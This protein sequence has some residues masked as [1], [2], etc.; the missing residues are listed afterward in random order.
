MTSHRRTLVGVILFS[1]LASGACGDSVPVAQF[2]PIPNLATSAQASP[3][4]SPSPSPKPS[5]VALAPPTS[6]PAPAPSCTALTLT[7]FDA[8]SDGPA[9]V[10][11]TWS[12]R[13]GCAPFRGEVGA[14]SY[15]AG[16]G[17]VRISSGSGSVHVLVSPCIPNTSAV[18]SVY[19]QLQD[20]GGHVI[21]PG[22]AVK[23][24]TVS[25]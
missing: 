18:F 3:S 10:L 15:T 11:A 9:Q 23:Q 1:L 13:G 21:T 25:C 4:L 24:I 12:T 20:G 5:S 6:H 17:S 7:G 22:Q 19:L 16:F 14:N 2:A 8:R